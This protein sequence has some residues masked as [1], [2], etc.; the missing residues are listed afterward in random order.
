[1]ID[2]D[3]SIANTSGQTG[4]NGKS[5]YALWMNNSSNYEI[6]RN[7]IDAGNASNGSNGASGGNGGDDYN[8]AD[9]QCSIN[10]TS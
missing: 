1:M 9:S 3:I 10:R 8:S 4:I 5:N 2:L 7:T 6:I